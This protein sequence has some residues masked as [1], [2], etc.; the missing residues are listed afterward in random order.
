MK[1]M[2]FTSK[3][4]SNNTKVGA[5]LDMSRQDSNCLDSCYVSSVCYINNNIQDK[6]NKGYIKKMKRNFKLSLSSKFVRIMRK[7]LIK[8]NLHTLRFFSNGDI[9]FNDFIKSDIQLKNIF[10]LCN[11]LRREYWLITRNSNALFKFMQNNEKPLFL[12][13]MLSVKEDTITESFKNQCEDYKIQLSYITDNKKLS[14]CPASKS[15][16][17]INTCVSHNCNSC[18]QYSKTPK[19]FMIHG[20]G[21]KSKFKVLKNE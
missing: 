10:S 7:E 19:V 20:Q 4:L 1:S 5:S 3:Y 6:I 16:R 8:N 12:N 2:N 17:K 14:N 9:I 15:K 21:N 13:I 11:S 18:F